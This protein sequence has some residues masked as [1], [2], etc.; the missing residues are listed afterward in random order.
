MTDHTTLE[1]GTYHETREPRV[2]WGARLIYAEV[3]DGG[4]GIVPDRQDAVGPDEER[5]AFLAYLNEVVGDAP[6]EEARRLM[7]EGLM[8]EKATVDF[9]LYEDERVRIT[10]SPQHSYGYLYV[11]AVDKS[12]R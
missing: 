5:A 8:T 2:G 1:Y 10:A 3:R 7:G 11:T 12:E 6:F 4:K 9:L